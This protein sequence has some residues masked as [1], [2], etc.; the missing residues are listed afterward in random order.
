MRRQVYKIITPQG[1][2]IKC[3]NLAAFAKRH[4]FP[5]DNIY[6]GVRRPIKRQ[7]YI[8]SIWRVRLTTCNTEHAQQIE[9]DEGY[10]THFSHRH[11]PPIKLS[12]S[13]RALGKEEIPGPTKRPGISPPKL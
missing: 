12:G 4:S 6:P 9:Q 5:I 10:Q 13:G 11:H 8:I 3:T 1:K 7:G 2:K